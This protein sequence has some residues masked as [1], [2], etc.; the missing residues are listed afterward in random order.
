MGLLA[1]GDVIDITG[2][3]T[4]NIA[5]E[6][7]GK[8]NVV[9]KGKRCKYQAGWG[10]DHLGYGP[11]KYH[12]GSTPS[13]S[14]SAHKEAA[15]DHAR[16][17]GGEV[18]M[19]PVDALL[20]AVRLGAGAVAY[21]QDLLLRDDLPVEVALAVEESYGAERD[22]MAKTAALCIGAGLAEKRVRLA[23]QQG[24]MLATILEASLEKAGLK[25]A[26]ILEVK[27]HAAALMVA[28]PGVAQ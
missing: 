18:D 28:L 16:K 10:T 23:E 3:D 27:K 4:T 2:Q 8:C 6:V 25:P 9:R 11:C 22:R 26:K 20:W 21:W 12:M 24:L 17:L 14:L 13:V 19:N 5:P 7:E 1:M 15:I